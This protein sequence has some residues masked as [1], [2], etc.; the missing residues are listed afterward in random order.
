MSNP[1]NPLNEQIAGEL[2]SAAYTKPTAQFTPAQN[3][4][5]GWRDITGELQDK[6]RTPYHDGGVNPAKASNEFRVFANDSTHQLVVAF[7]GSDSLQNWKSDLNP[8]DQGY[9]SYQ[10]IQQNAQKYLDEVKRDPAYK[11][12]AQFTDGHS[13]GGGM[14]QCFAVQNNLSGFGQNSLP[15]P[16]KFIKNYTSASN[17][18]GQQAFEKDLATQRGTHKF[19]E[20]NVSGDIATNFY[21]ASNHLTGG[22]YINKNPRT[23][24]SPYGKL[25]V[26]ADAVGLPLV[27]AGLGAKAHMIGSYEKYIEKAGQYGNWAPEGKGPDVG[28]A[29]LNRET[30]AALP[31]N[32]GRKETTD[33]MLAALLSDDHNVMHAGITAGLATHASQQNLQHA[34]LA[35][36][37]EQANQSQH[38]PAPQQAQ[39]PSVRMK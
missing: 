4:P 19:D 8:L 23:L 28:N 16:E 2:S 21:S 20:V 24:D 36:H 29:P 35:A 9:S 38:Q 6:T 11:N 13:L 14:A 7:K 34:N 15:I 26:A 22:Q 32:A 12:Y 27:S 3:L 37:A 18:H 10:A 39:S 31:A 25:E 5:A 30:A 1:V 33:H 17:E